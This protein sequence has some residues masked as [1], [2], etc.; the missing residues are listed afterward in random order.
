MTRSESPAG[1]RRDAREARVGGLRRAARVRTTRAGTWFPARTEDGAE[2]GL[3]LVHP[4]VEPRD[5]VDTLTR[6]DELGVPGA[7]PTR[8]R[9][10]TEAGRKWLVSEVS[11]V[12][13]LADALDE[14]G[15]HRT[16]ATAAALLCDLGATLLTVH[17]GGLVHG[18]LGAGAVVVG[19]S[20][21]ALLTDWATAPEATPADDVA[22]WSGLAGELAER[23]SPAHP[24]A[25]TLADAAGVARASGLTAGCARLAALAERADRTALARLADRRITEGPRRRKPRRPAPPP[26][27]PELAAL[28]ELPPAPPPPAEPPA[29]PPHVTSSLTA[30]P[31]VVPPPPAAPEAPPAAATHPPALASAPPAAPPAAQ[32]PA[33]QPPAAT[34]GGDGAAPGPATEESRRGSVARMVLIGVL[35]VALGVVSGLLYLRLARPSSADAMSVTSVDVLAARRGA[36]CMLYASV[37]TNGEAGTL[38]YRWSNGSDA[39]PVMTLSVAPG[40]KQLVL[41]RQW[42]PP[43]DTPA[44]DTGLA[45]TMSI[46]LLSPT[47]ATA[48]V[49]PAAGC[50]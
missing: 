36:L 20:G 37:A 15:A 5:L 26:L 33:A 34:A 11:P 28:D 10:V 49:Q 38:T 45:A 22:A 35:V 25:G 27:P 42:Q 29:A 13:A 40:Q 9:L 4:G 24:D 3:L 12:P 23:W 19:R 50:L 16:P 14:D 47:P 8:A 41:G 44:G 7:L 18:R 2:A 1:P 30:S 21:D 6:L 31:P 32:P 39:E 17:R 43:T 48:T 46:Q